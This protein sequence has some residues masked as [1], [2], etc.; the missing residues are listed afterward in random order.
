MKIVSFPKQNIFLYKTDDTSFHEAVKAFLKIFKLYLEMLSVWTELALLLRLLQ[1]SFPKLPL[2]V[3][4]H[5]R[6]PKY[7]IRA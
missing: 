3:A 5:L 4:F 6:K 2:A 1:R 7:L